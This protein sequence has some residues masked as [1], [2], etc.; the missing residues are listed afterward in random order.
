MIPAR[1][2]FRVTLDMYYSSLPDEYKQLRL[3]NNRNAMVFA[4][5]IRLMFRVAGQKKTGGG[6]LGR[7]A[8]LPFLHA[9]E[10]FIVGRS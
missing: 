3:I 7:S 6:N 9:T 8:A 1:D 10:I 4:N 5:K 2:Q